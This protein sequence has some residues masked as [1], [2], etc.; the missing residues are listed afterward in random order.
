MVKEAVTFASG[1]CLPVVAA[2]STSTVSACMRTCV[3]GLPGWN[4]ASF[5]RRRRG[6]ISAGGRD[7]EPEKDKK[8]DHNRVLRGSETA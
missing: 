7:I 1:F 4:V 3:S 2:T 8:E 5:G 6:D